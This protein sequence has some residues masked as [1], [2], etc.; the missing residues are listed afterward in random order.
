HPN[1]L[2]MMSGTV[3]PAGK[4]G[5]PVLE[6]N[7]DS[8]ATYSVS[9][10]TMPEVLEDAGVSWKVYN[11]V[12]TPY[13]PAFIEQHGLLISDAI[14]PYFKQYSNP[15]S[16]LYQKAFLPLYP[17]D[18]AADVR[19]GT[20][21]AVSW[22]TPPDGYDEHPPAPPAMG[23]WYTSQVLRTLM[24][25]PK[26]WAKTVVFHCYDE[27]DGFFD[28]VPPPVPPAGTAGEY[29]TTSPLP[30]TAQGVAGPV[31]LGYR[32]PMLVISP[33]SRG[34][35]VA[36]EVADHTSQLRFLEA[37]FGVKAPNISAWR[38]KH[39]GDLTSTLHMGHA[40]TAVPKLPSTAHDQQADMA[41]LGCTSADLVE[42]GD[43]QPVYPV[44]AHQ[45]MPRQEIR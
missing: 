24:S 18:F 1:R 15:S 38:R 26:V 35:H 29:V 8:D 22:V 5:G 31:G 27:N 36:S 41:A 9:W 37:R 21:P 28:H 33:F 42:A 12:G 25:N 34:G 6:T 14:L 44:P 3:D 17:T 11:P 43:N 16:A 4:A 23:E 40:Q 19:K 2:M 30:S 13:T 7:E 32:V 10:D 39:T 20:L 45:T